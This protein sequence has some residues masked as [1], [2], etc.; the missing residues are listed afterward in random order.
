MSIVDLKEAVAALRAGD[1]VAIPTETVYGLAGRI[2]RE[3]TL[4]QIFAVKQRPFFDPLIVHVAELA[5]A[6]ALT[7]EWPEIFDDL[8]RAFWPGPLTLVA[9]KTDAVS[10]LITSGLDTVALRCPRHQLALEIIR[11]VGVPLAGPSAN[12]FGRTSPTRAQDVKD[13]FV[14]EVSVVDGGPCEIGLESTVIQAQRQGDTWKIGILRPGGVSRAQLQAV[15]EP[16][17]KVEIER[18]H[19]VASPGHL[20]AHYQPTNPVVIV[21]GP[22]PEDKAPIEHALSRPLERVHTLI[23]PATPELAARTLYAEFRRLSEQPGAIVVQ[24]IAANS[25][26]DWEAI[27]DR[28]ERASSARI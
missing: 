2:D 20:K 18:L 17:Y 14:D 8:A 16:K 9:P 4:R 1:V 19:S 3:Q 26:P 7:A 13:E 22:I 12:R 27:W 25:G 5:Q 28:I 21:R 6:R 23:L 11:Q 10:S 24:Q 15:L